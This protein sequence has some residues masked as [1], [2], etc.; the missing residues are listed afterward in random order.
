[1]L[2]PDTLM[3]ALAAPQG[4]S[5]G[6]YLSSFHIFSFTSEKAKNGILVKRICDHMFIYR[7]FKWKYEKQSEEISP[8]STWLT[9]VGKGYPA[10][11]QLQPSALDLASHQTASALRLFLP[12]YRCGI[13]CCCQSTHVYNACAP[14]SMALK[15]PPFQK[16]QKKY[17]SELSIQREAGTGRL[18]GL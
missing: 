16:K 12:R 6:A 3:Q 13:P 5:G 7:A 4:P 2:T 15:G 10:H 8:A 1:M 14:K 9:A 18:R 17:S 11:S